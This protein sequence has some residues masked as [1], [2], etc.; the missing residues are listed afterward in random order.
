MTAGTP[1][2]A[3]V[4]PDPVF[5]TSP[6]L[7]RMLESAIDRVLAVDAHGHRIYSSPSFD[8][9]VGGDGRLPLNTSAPPPYVPAD[10]H[11]AY[12]RLLGAVPQVLVQDK[13]AC[14]RLVVSRAD[15]DRVPVDVTVGALVP[16]RGD[17]VSI[18]LFRPREMHDG[19]WRA[20]IDGAS[21]GIGHWRDAGHPHP[22]TPLTR[23]EREVLELLLEGWRVQSI[24]SALYL[25]EHT[26]RNHLKAIF[27]K[28]G[29]HSQKDLI[30]MVRSQHTSP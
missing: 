5:P 12:F 3:I 21:R 10:Q 30:E 18:W 8:S 1:L 20:G 6:F 29:A 17:A 19:G 14:G 4:Q 26:V 2:R 11:G 13:T 9:M 23:R 22:D 7:K 24:A 28:L 25:S 16:P 27:R 15:R